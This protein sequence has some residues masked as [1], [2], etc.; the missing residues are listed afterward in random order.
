MKNIKIGM[1]MTII[2]KKLELD[3]SFEILALITLEKLLLNL[4]S[5]DEKNGN[6]KRF[7]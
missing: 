3:T 2:I 1:K 5:K 4:Y 6:A 7:K